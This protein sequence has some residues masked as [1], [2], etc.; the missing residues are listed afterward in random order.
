MTVDVLM[1]FQKF[2]SQPVLITTPFALEEDQESTLELNKQLSDL[3]KHCNFNLL[4]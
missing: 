3:K 2:D 4:Q 1:I